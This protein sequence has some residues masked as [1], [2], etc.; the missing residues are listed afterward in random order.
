MDPKLTGLWPNFTWTFSK[1]IIVY[2]PWNIL[3][4]ILMI[5]G[6]IKVNKY[7]FIMHAWYNG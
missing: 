7:K 2:S 4:A 6:E 5:S 3:K 1:L